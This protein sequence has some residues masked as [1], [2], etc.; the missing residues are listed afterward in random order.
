MELYVCV[1]YSS[2]GQ[3]FPFKLTQISTWFQI[4]DTNCLEIKKI[5]WDGSDVKF[6]KKSDEWAINVTDIKEW[7]KENSEATVISVQTHSLSSFQDLRK[8]MPAAQLF[9][10]FLF[11]Q[12]LRHLQVCIWES[13]GWLKGLE[14]AGRSLALCWPFFHWWCTS[15]QSFS[16]T[17]LAYT[18]GF[19]MKVCHSYE[20]PPSHRQPNRKTNNF[21]SPTVDFCSHD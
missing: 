11:L 12:A 20:W 6:K 7:L 13:W 5:Y 18:T 4:I 15:Q 1:W 16:C 19:T 8:L 9:F 17:R 14:D 3:C 2:K 21:L 10:F